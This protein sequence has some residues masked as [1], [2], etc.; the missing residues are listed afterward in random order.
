MLLYLY[1]MQVCFNDLI[2]LEDLFDQITPTTY[3][4]INDS[5]IEDFKESIQYFIDDYVDTHIES[6]KEKGFETMMFED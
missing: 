6:Y 3:N 1:N 2:N 5:D 4:D